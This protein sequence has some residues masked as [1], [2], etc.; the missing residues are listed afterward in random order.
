MVVF[1]TLFSVYCLIHLGTCFLEKE[2][3]RK[4]TKVFIIPFLMIGLFITKT[5]NLFL[6]IGLTLGWIGDIFLLFTNKKQFFIVG[7][8]AFGFGHIAYIC[9]TV[10]V[11]INKYTFSDIPLWAIITLTILAIVFLILT[12]TKTKKHLGKLSFLIAF[13]F[14]ILIIAILTAYITS[15]Y[16]LSIGFAIFVISDS[17]LSIN[18][19]VRPIKRDHFYIMSTY[20]LAQTLIVISFIIY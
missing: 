18:K 1:W 9:A 3:L 4:I 17:I 6:F 8:T 19:F 5:Y 20:I 7:A 2:R 14:Y 11:F 16:L 12:F 15:Y 10:Q 13:Y